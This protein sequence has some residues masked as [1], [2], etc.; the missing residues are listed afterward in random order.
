VRYGTEVCCAA[1]GTVA[2]VGTGAAWWSVVWLIQ[3]RREGNRRL[4][5]FCCHAAVASGTGAV[6]W[7]LPQ[8]LSLGFDGKI[9]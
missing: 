9:F 6:W 2:W 1:L 4:D 5:K 7:A 3:I 8:G